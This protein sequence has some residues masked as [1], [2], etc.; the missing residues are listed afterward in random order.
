MKHVFRA[1]PLLVL[2]AASLLCTANDKKNQTPAKVVDSGSFGIF[3]KGQRVGTEKFEIAQQGNGNIT[4][5]E[6]KVDDGANKA[7]QKTE[8]QLSGTGELRHYSWNELSPGKAQA[9][10]DPDQQFL[11]ERIVPSPSEKAIDQPFI[12]PA[13]T[14]I[15]DDYF[16]SQRELLTWRYLGSSCSQNAN[17]Q[18][19]CKLSKSQFGVLIPRQRM[20]ALVTVEF[21]GKE[22]VIIRGQQVELNRFNL[23]GEG[24]DWALWFDDTHKLQRVVIA[25]DFTEVVRD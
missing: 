15:L 2:L 24:M 22:K 11:M 10:V 9:T 25:S 19:E 16:F 23:Q 20:S 14:A 17:G 7:V 8:M 4:H 3:I 1:L 18:T 21:I 6:L 12:L 5:A 13:S